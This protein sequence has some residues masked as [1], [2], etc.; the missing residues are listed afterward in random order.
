M[1][2]ERFFIDA[3]FKKGGILLIKEEEFH[4][5]AHVTRVRAKETI[6]LVNG[7]GD[8][9]TAY[10]ESIEKH[11]AT[12][13]L[14]TVETTKPPARSLILAQALTRPSRL[15]YIVEK[16]VEL[17]ITE[18]WL[19]EGILSEKKI[20]PSQEKRIHT[21]LISALKQCGR[22][23]LPKLILAPPL[24]S[25]K[26]DELLA[27]AFF[28]DTK[29]EA[30]SFLSALS[31]E[32]S[33]SY[34]VVIGPEKGFHAKETLFMEKN[35]QIQGISLHKNILRA[36]TAAICALSLASAFYYS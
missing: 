3:C 10:V 24:L 11:H 15:E 16:S 19:F 29:P 5:L 13:C 14:Q 7:K 35:L 2:A 18:L 8:L 26:K 22:L 23:F 21:I 9:A 6:E 32:K 31:K 12:V 25:W 27:T 34:L 30:P 36:D 28:G 1:P 20:S 33:S 17:G 4:H